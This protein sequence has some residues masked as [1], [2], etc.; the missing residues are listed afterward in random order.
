MPGNT[1]TENALLEALRR[2]AKVYQQ[3]ARTLD[4]R[5]GNDDDMILGGDKASHHSDGGYVEKWEQRKKRRAAEAA[6]AKAAL[7]PNPQIIPRNVTVSL[8][9]REAAIAKGL[10][11]YYTGQKC[12]H[13]HLCER[14]V[15]TRTCVEC[16]RAAQLNSKIE[17]GREARRL[18]KAEG[19]TR[20]FSEQKC[21]HGHV[22]KRL[23]S[24]GQCV[25]CHNIRVTKQRRRISLNRTAPQSEQTN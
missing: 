25:E 1:K 12:A 6:A 13:G 11:R 17:R 19:R 14:I 24:T 23:V 20:Y 22:A 8:I 16:H 3:R 7:H 18:A 15:S 10:T 21:P 2:D 9:S 4:W 5:E